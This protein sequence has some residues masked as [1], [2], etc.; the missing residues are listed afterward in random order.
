MTTDKHDS[1]E[2]DLTVGIVQLKVM[3]AGIEAE[4]QQVYKRVRELSAQLDE[5][6]KLAIRVKAKIEQIDPPP[7]DRWPTPRQ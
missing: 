1:S 5:L 7:P 2:D 3:S 4:I 6:N